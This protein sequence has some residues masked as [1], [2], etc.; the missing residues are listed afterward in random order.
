MQQNN[1]QQGCPKRPL[2]DQGSNSPQEASSGGAGQESAPPCI[3]NKQQMPP[4]QASVAPEAGNHTD[5]PH[6]Q[7]TQSV[8][9]GASQVQAVHNVQN[10]AAFNPIPPSG[11]P[12][13]PQ[14]F[15]AKPRSPKRGW[16]VALVAVVLLFVVLMTSIFS[17]SNTFLNMTSLGYNSGTSIPV[18]TTGDSIA[19]IPI[20][21]TI[22][23][24]GTTASPEGLKSKLDEAES[25]PDI[26]AV[27]LRVDSG[28]GTATAGEEMAEY[29]RAF[30]KPVVVS[31]AST[32][33]S[34]AYQ[35][36]SQAD[37]I[38]VAR[39]TAIGSIGAAIQIT[40]LSGLY[41]KLGINIQDV[42]SADSKDSGY[43]TRPLTEEERAHYQDIVNQANE[44]FIKT[45][46]EGRGMSIEEVRKL[47]TGMTYTGTDAVENGLADEIGTL[48]QACDQA[49]LL[50][51][52]S[53][54]YNTVYLQDSFSTL[55]NLLSLK[56]S[57][58]QELI[59]ALKE[60]ESDDSLSH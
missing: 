38:Y 29:V 54:G 17:C 13:I 15:N 6:A 9:Q 23:Y 49:A 47:A 60:L 18:L 34:A 56:Q 45:V 52:I 55:E 20:S 33:A 30:S 19:V 57:S 21:G 59:D 25:N 35:I 1:E 41:E 22:Q 58:N 14:Q 2:I 48:E 11:A 24:D 42:T 50:A 16:I 51:G 37:A 4:A 10:Q 5:Q 40:D 32:N 7:V 3:H 36:S 44:T 26:K 27:V 12:V 46:A 28:G 39:T 8:S 31:S 53:G 43:G